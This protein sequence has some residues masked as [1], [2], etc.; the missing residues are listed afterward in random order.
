MTAADTPPPH[1]PLTAAAS[2]LQLRH[3][4]SHQ[5]PRDLDVRAALPAMQRWTVHARAASLVAELEATKAAE[6]ILDN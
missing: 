6:W 3:R 4:I 2:E 1:D 5:P